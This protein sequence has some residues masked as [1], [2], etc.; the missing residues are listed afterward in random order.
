[1]KGMKNRSTR[2]RFR[3]SYYNI[4]SQGSSPEYR[5]R[6]NRMR[7]FL[8]KTSKGYRKKDDIFYVGGAHSSPPSLLWVPPTPKRGGPVAKPAFLLPLVYTYCI[9]DIPMPDD[10]A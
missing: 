3:T 4:D 8:K 10:G 2:I 5:A 9:L 7:T 1:M 6:G